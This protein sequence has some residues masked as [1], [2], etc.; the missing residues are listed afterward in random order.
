MHALGVATRQDAEAVVLDLV[1]S[2]GTARRSFGR[3][4]QA[5][6]DKS[7]YEAVAL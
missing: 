1:Q 5:G 2:S 3:R 6:L 4:R 7:G